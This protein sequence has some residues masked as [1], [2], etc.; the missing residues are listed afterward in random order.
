MSPPI[1]ELVAS[2]DGARLWSDLEA[3]ATFRDEGASPHTRRAFGD[4]YETARAWLREQMDEAGLTTRRDAAGSLI[5]HQPGAHDL[6][7]LVVGSHIDTVDG[8]GRFDGALGVLAAVE[9][10]RSLA[11]ADY[12]LAHPIEVVDFT[13][14][15]PNRYGSSCIGSRAWSGTLDARLLALT[16]ADGETLAEA[17]R[18]AGGEIEQLGTARRSAESIA[19]YI[20]LHIEQGPVLEREQLDVGVVSGI[21][22]IR[23]VHAR[24]TGRAAHAGTTPVGTR[25]DALAVASEVVLA[26]EQEARAAAGELI[27]TVGRLAVEPNA[28]NV[29]PGLVEL[30]LEVR[31]LDEQRLDAS[32]ERIEATAQKAGADRQVAVAFSLLSELPAVAADPRLVAALEEGAAVAGAGTMRQPSWGGHDASQIARVA[33]VGMLFA[34]SRDGLSHH[35]DEWTSPEQCAIAGRTLLAGLALLDEQLAG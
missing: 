18:R 33:P 26:V 21:V 30:S 13:A 11:R 19:A 12:V 10:V 14:E 7:P 24:L 1:A 20:E 25:R 17:M 29:V 22:G 6:P 9:L 28:P 23:R 31:S 34:P 5:G 15:E 35:P 3:L 2:F 8:G 32:L 27:G 16:D 4:S